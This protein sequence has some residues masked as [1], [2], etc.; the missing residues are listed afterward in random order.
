MCVCV[1]VC[2]CVCVWDWST[3]VSNCAL[4]CVRLYIC[5]Y[6][7]MRVRVCETNSHTHV[8]TFNTPE[9]NCQ[10]LKQERRRESLLI[11]ILHTSALSTQTDH[12]HGGGRGERERG[13]IASEKQDTLSE[14]VVSLRT[15]ATFVT[16]LIS[17]T[18]FS[19]LEPVL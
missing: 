17:R 13:K 2:L 4:L 14:V 8:S 1:R 3:N 11:W 19:S 6:M 12:G 9:Q 16:W 10:D 15:V 7:C 5:V 18:E